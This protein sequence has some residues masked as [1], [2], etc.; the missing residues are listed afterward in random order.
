MASFLQ[1]VPAE[2]VPDCPGRKGAVCG[3]SE[4]ADEPARCEPV[5]E[6]FS[7]S[8]ND[9]QGSHA[10]TTARL[11]GRLLMDWRVMWWFLSRTPGTHARALSWKGRCSGT[12]TS[13]AGVGIEGL[14]MGGSDLQE[15]EGGRMD[16]SVAVSASNGGSGIL[17]SRGCRGRS[18]SAVTASECPHRKAK[19]VED[20]PVGAERSAFFRLTAVGAPRRLGGR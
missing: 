9:L 8:A 14:V 19:I 12:R 18:I 16:F 4:R 10:G 3:P 7:L 5:S 2:R 11:R 15:Y 20:E 17:L 13:G 6:L 1:P